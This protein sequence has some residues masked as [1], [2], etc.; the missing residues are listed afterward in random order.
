LN[1]QLPEPVSSAE[2]HFVESQIGEIQIT[3]YL[4]L[5]FLLQ[6]KAGQVRPI[7][8]SWKLR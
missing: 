8:I 1:E 5:L 4:G 3:A 2:D 6:A 7:A